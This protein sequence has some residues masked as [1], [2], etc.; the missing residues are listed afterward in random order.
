[1]HYYL[2]SNDTETEGRWERRLTDHGFDVVEEY[3]T[4][5]V[6]VTLGGDGTILY[7]ARTYSD[8][9][10]L[11]VRTGDSVGYQTHL[12][13]DQLLAA[14]ER[15]EADP[16][17]ES[18]TT[19]EH[20]KLGAY[21]DG[22][23]L[24]DGFRALNEINLHHSAPTLAAVFTVRIHDRGTTEVFERLIGDGALVATPFGSSAYYR[25]VTGGS[26]TEGLGVAF[27]NVHTPVDTPSFR[28]LSPDSTV[29]FELLESD[30]ASGAVLVRDNDSETYELSVG[31]SI[32][33]RQSAESLT[34]LRP[35]ASAE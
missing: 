17:G 25:S 18:Y 16:A 19:V 9:T 6:I 28:V 13:T 15:I 12:E 4:D 8:P 14:L 3:D 34:V 26:F 7:A 30:H 31:E 23:E 27:N 2:V 22:T 20:R 11:P 1:M 21:R 5:A 32:E 33:I 29:E 35:R 10:V 24:H